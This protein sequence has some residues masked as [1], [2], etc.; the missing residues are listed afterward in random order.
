L[1][2]TPPPK[3]PVKWA[4]RAV[5][6]VAPGLSVR[7]R[8]LKKKRAGDVT[9]SVI[10]RLVMPGDQVLDVGAYRGVYSLDLSRRVGRHGKVWSI[11]P[12]P[13]NVE[14]LKRAVGGRGNITICA[15]A[16]S[17]R[18]GRQMLKVPVYRGHQLGALATLGQAPE[19][20]RSVAVDMITIDELLE[21]ADGGRRPL[22]FLR[23]D[24]VGHEAAALAGA[25]RT[26]RTLRP[27]IWVEIEQRHQQ[28]PIQGTLDR[29]MAYGYEGYFARHRHLFPLAALDLE[30]DQLRFVGPKF[31][32]YHMP[33]N[34]VH[35]FLFVAP[36]TDLGSLFVR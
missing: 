21:T 9:L 33:L 36:G 19:H 4:E 13:T 30:R 31:V 14:A 15:A 8:H 24:V 22:R 6:R 5:D 26:L 28:R 11:E 35:Y 32:P 25:D 12:F 10:E 34:Y 27:A 29:L 16:A 17:D 1:A 2:P 20:S 18:A 7:A 23:C 3:S